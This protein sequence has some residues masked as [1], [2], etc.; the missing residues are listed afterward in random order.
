MINP[1]QIQLMKVLEEERLQEAANRRRYGKPESVVAT[2][3]VRLRNALKAKKSQ[4]ARVAPA[5]P[6]KAHS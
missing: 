6:R 1:T 5:A 3:F 2:L 4:P